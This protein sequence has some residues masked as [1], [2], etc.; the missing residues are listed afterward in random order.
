MHSAEVE[1][2][3]SIDFTDPNDI[4]VNDCSQFYNTEESEKNDGVESP[5]IDNLRNASQKFRKCQ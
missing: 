4:K 1:N 5:K 2:F 3:V